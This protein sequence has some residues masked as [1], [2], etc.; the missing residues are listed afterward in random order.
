MG[1]CQPSVTNLRLACATPKFHHF[2]VNICI[3]TPTG[4]LPTPFSPSR[5]LGVECGNVVD[6]SRHF[7]MLKN[8]W[9]GIKHVHIQISTVHMPYR[10]IFKVTRHGNNAYSIPHLNVTRSFL[11]RM[12]SDYCI[13]ENSL[14]SMPRIQLMY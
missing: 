1:K 12:S 3:C 7:F 5:C 10:P 11:P 2:N 14:V 13:T 8:K 6:Q 9:Y 4:T